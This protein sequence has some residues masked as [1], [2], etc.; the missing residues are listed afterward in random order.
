MTF[1]D[2]VLLMKRTAILVNK[3]GRGRDIEL[4]YFFKLC[5]HIEAIILDWEKNATPA[6]LNNI[7]I[8]KLLYE[9][10]RG[11]I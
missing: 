3:Q 7:K 2:L 8:K 1:H 10:H 6:I 9:R 5:A 4:H 11:D